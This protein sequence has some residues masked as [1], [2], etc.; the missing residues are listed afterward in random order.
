MHL[1]GADEVRRALGWQVLLDGIREMFRSGC[2]TPI[3]HHHDVPMAGEPAAAMLLMPAWISGRYIGVKIANVVPGNASRSLP[4]VSSSYILSDGR[5]GEIVAVIEGGE[6]TARRTAAA[7][8]LAATYLA[9]ADVR[10]LLIVGTGRVARNLAEAHS[11]VRAYETVSIWGRNLSKAEAIAAELAQG[12]IPAV[13]V[14]DLRQAAQEADVIS[15]ATMSTDPI[16]SGQWVRPGTHVD[17]V[18]AFRP[19]MREADESLMTRGRVFVDTRAGALAEAGEVIHA[20]SSGALAPTDIVGDLFDLANDR[21]PGRQSDAEITVFKS[22]GTALEDLAA[23]ILV[24]E[25]GV[26]RC[27]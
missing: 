14:G 4:A 1:Y 17:L 7:S 16:L 5:T 21:H 27:A 23:A 26:A 15:C 25:A 8:A 22:V 10:R 2:E 24:H 11:V 6:L 13:A 12:G 18:G 20:I 3:R 19:S 9:R